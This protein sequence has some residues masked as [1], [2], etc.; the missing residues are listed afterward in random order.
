MSEPATKAIE[1]AGDV[2]AK[3]AAAAPAR[4]VPQITRDRMKEV[5]FNRVRYEIILPSGVEPD[6]ILPVAYWSHVAE[7][8]KAAKDQGSTVEIVALAE[9]LKWEGELRVVDAGTNWARVIFKTTEDGKRLITKLGG[10]QAHKISLLAGHTVNY[11]GVFAKWRIVRDADGQVLSDKHN[12]EGDAYR[13]LSDYAKSIQP[14]G[15]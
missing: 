9:D 13:W 14:R 11:G 4:L 5:Q 3:T 8:F 15:R 2:A 10:L 6:D 12:T 7:D 1:G